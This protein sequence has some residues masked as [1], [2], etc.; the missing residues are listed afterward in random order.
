MYRHY[1][2]LLNQ[3]LKQT[4]M[5]LQTILAILYA[6]GH[7]NIVSKAVA[8]DN[9]LDNQ[10]YNTLKCTLSKDKLPADKQFKDG[11]SSG[12]VELHIIGYNQFKLEN[13]YLVQLPNGNT[14]WRSYSDYNNREYI[15][16]IVDIPEIIA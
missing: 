16:E 14:E 15:T 6:N 7:E 5:T 4:I 9:N 3:P 13:N 1:N 12:T 8:I 10:E 2:Q 11:K